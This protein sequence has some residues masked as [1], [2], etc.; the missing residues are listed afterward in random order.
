[1]EIYLSSGQGIHFWST[2][3]VLLLN[4]SEICFIVLVYLSLLID[5]VVITTPAQV[6]WYVTPA[7]GVTALPMLMSPLAPDS[8]FSWSSP[9][10]VAHRQMPF[11]FLP[12]QNKY[13]FA[14]LTCLVKTV[15]PENKRGEKTVNITW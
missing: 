15:S 14:T 8:S 9:T 2:V 12:S 7:S 6:A 13:I 3:V 1:M 4:V 5:L 11:I 10:L